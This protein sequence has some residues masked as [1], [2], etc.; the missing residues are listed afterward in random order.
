ML[1]KL[2]RALIPVVEQ[3]LSIDSQAVI[4]ILIR[5]AELVRVHVLE[6]VIAEVS[7]AEMPALSL[8]SLV[9]ANGVQR[10]KCV[11]RK[12]GISSKATNISHT[13]ICF[14]NLLVIL[15]D[16]GRPNDGK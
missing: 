14:M 1:A 6:I 8:D 12:H 4:T 2:K 16:N 15:L 7:R 9:Q 5:V 10:A 3:D 13:A 11:W